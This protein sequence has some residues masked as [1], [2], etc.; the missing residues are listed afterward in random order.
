ME[1]YYHVGQKKIFFYN[2]LVWWKLLS[3][4]RNSSFFCQGN[5][6]NFIFIEEQNTEKNVWVGYGKGQNANDIKRGFFLSFLGLPS[7]LK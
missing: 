7:A 2:L 3:D 6:S 1:I 4:I 5:I